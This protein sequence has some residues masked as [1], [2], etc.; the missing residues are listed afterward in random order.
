MTAAGIEA[1]APMTDPSSTARTPFEPTDRFVDRHIGPDRRE[2]AEMLATVGYED[3]ESLMNAAIPGS[4]RYRD[5]LRLDAPATS[6]GLS[7][8]EALEAIRRMCD[9]NQCWKS[10]IGMG[11]HGTIT[12]AVILRNIVENPC[13]YTQYT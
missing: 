13:W 9:E 7:E 3:I 12:P 1:K 5:E 10:H 8:A 6:H 2:I 4:L 11:Y